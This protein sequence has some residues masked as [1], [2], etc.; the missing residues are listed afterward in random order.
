MENTLESRSP[1]A[2]LA[3]M[4]I[5]T[6]LS[7][8]CG[9]DSDGIVAE[10][11]A[12]V[13]EQEGNPEPTAPD[14]DFG[15]YDA[16]VEQFVSDH[17]LAGATTAVVH[18]DLGVVHV[19]G[20]GGF[21]TDRLSLLASSSKILSVG[22]LMRLMDQGQ[23]DIDMPI[24]TYLDDAFGAG[25]NDKGTITAA[26][27]VSNSSGLPSLADSA[28]FAPYLCQYLSTGTLQDCAK[29]IYTTVED[30]PERTPPDTKF[31]YGGGPWQLAGGLAEVAG[32]KPWAE[33]VQETYV[34]PCGVD[35]LGYVNQFQVAG[36]TYPEVF[37][38]NPDN[39]GGFDNPSIEGG[40]HIR[41]EDYGRLLL[42]HLRGGMCDGGRVLSEAAVA[43][44]QE[45]RIMAYGGMTPSPTLQGYGLGWWIDRNNEG[46]VVDGGAYGATPF[47]DNE[48]GYGAIIIFEAQAAL[49]PMVYALVKPELDALFEGL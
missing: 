33:L 7:I 40:A 12:G 46:V 9:D 14:L 47:L 8:G 10:P 43:R 6:T 24:G 28:T 1:G 48:R 39:V 3:A 29:T 26:Q 4:G 5:L 18:R 19:A 42:M 30:E 38:Q 16:I 20:Y 34:E 11:D 23:L 21:A 32:G 15:A 44:M 37:E 49:G 45:D 27:L 22:V 17:E 36:T 31:R 13:L 41:P 2:W 35:S 25:G